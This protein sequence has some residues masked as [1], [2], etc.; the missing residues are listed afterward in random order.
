[1]AHIEPVCP[2][3]HRICKL[4]QKSALAYRHGFVCVSCAYYAAVARLCYNQY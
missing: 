3:F 2:I 4:A 1:M